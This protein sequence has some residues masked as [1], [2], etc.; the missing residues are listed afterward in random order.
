MLIKTKWRS[1]FLNSTS[2]LKEDNVRI[3]DLFSEPAVLELCMH[4][5]CRY[6]IIYL[7]DENELRNWTFITRRAF[8]YRHSSGYN[9]CIFSSIMHLVLWNMRESKRKYY[10]FWKVD[11]DSM[12][13]IFRSKS[14][15]WTVAHVFLWRQPKFYSSCRNI[16]DNFDNPAGSH[17]H[18]FLCPSQ[19]PVVS[20]SMQ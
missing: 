13:C 4:T 3:G 11:I 20:L 7:D 6:W 1:F 5:I 12:W 8:T 19:N 18:F 15:M 16:F 17:F 9:S 10:K 14:V 2:K